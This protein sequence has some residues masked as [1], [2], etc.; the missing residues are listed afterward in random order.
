MDVNESIKMPF[1]PPQLNEF[2]LTEESIAWLDDTASLEQYRLLH[3][4]ASIAHE[5]V[6]GIDTFDVIFSQNR[7]TLGA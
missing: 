7:P 4:Y 6:S 1:L 2:G 3:E 5:V